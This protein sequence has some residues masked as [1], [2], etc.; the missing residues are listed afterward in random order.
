MCIR[1]SAGP[2]GVMLSNGPGDPAENTYQI[3]QIR[4]LLGK[5]PMFGI[6]LEMCIRDRVKSEDLL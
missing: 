6:C 4:K 3:E 2:D 1:D 5:V